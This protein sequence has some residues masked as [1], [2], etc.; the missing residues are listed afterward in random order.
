MIKTFS[1][2]PAE[3]NFRQIVCPL[4][5]STGYK[6]KWKKSEI[7][8]VKCSSCSLVFQ[9]PQPEAA[10]LGGRYDD[11]YFNYEIANEESFFRLMRLGLSDVRFFDYE[12]RMKSL[13][14]A[15]PLSFLDI[16]CATGALLRFMRERSWTV[17]GIEI[18]ARSADYGRRTHGL[19]IFTGT[20]E[21][22]EIPDN[23]FDVIHSS[24]LVEHLT[25]PALFFREAARILKPGGVIVTVTPDVSG[26]QAKLFGYGWRSAI[27]DHMFLFSKRTLRKMLVKNGFIIEKTATW[28]GLAAG[29]APYLIKTAADRI[30]KK[31]GFGD[32]VCILGVLPG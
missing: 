23:S 12:K 27:A 22:A 29:T 4:C 14:A 3:N 31:V 1:K 24:H 25:E 30:V 5:G 13:Q 17:K 6:P 8:F 32:V 26:F 9:N 18:C 11:E 21:A 7:P 19:D 15:E 28:G 20:I 16:G 10:E 2:H